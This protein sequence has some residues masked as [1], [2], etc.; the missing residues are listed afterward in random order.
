MTSP[1]IEDTRGADGALPPGRRRIATGDRMELGIRRKI[2]LV[3]VAALALTTA[4]H[5]LLA[6]YFTDRQNQ[7]AAFAL[8]D[9]DLLAWQNDLHDSTLQL[10]DRALITVSDAG[11]RNQLAEL[12]TLEIS[13]R[14]PV[15]AKEVTETS[16]TLGYVKSVSLSRLQVALRT[17]GFSSIAVRTGAT[18][19]HHVSTSDAG[20]MLPRNG[21]SV[22]ITTPMDAAGNLPLQSWPSWRESP[23]PPNLTR[24]LPPLTRPTTSF[25]VLEPD[26]TV[27]D[28]AVP[29]QGIID[30]VLVD[31]ENRPT[32]RF[33]SGVDIAGESRSAA[34]SEPGAHPSTFAVVV[35]RKVIDSAALQK[36]ARNTGKWPALFS[37]DGRHQHRLIDVGVSPRDLLKELK[38]TPDGSSPSYRGIV[39]TSQGSSYLA[40]R[41][42]DFEG[43]PRLVLALASSRQSTL[44]NIRETVTAILIASAG[45]LVVS[46][47]VGT[48]G[49]RRFL[50]PIVALTAAVK[51]RT[52]VT[53]AGDDAG[54][55]PLRAL[56]R[57]QPIEADAPDE[58]GDLARAFNTLLVKLHHSFETLEQRVQTR[59]EALRQ[60]TRYF[61]TLI[62]LLPMGVW[63]K[64]TESR[65][66]A[67][68]QSIAASSG[69]AVD[70]IVGKSDLEIWP[71]A[72]AEAQRSDDAAV[73][74]TRARRTVE[75]R[76]VRGTS[77]T[78]VE[79]Y[80][81][82][83]VDEDGT[84][85]GTVGIS[86]DISE[87][88]AAEA[89]REAA[90]DEARRLA[91]LR[92]DFL[93]QMSHELR[94]PLNG[95]LGYAQILLRDATL[96]ERQAG[97]LQV[98]QQ[99]GE[100]LL[101]LI[102]DLLDFAKIDSGKLELNPGT[103]PLDRFLRTIAG[104]I[105]VKAEQKGL[106]FVFEAA[107]DLPAAIRADEKRLREILFNLLANAI[108]F[109]DRG[110]ITFRVSTIAPAR[111]R[112]EVRDT[113]IGI[114]ADQIET[115]FQPFEQAGD[116]HR[117]AGG[118]GLGLAIGRQ[119]VRLMGG[120]IHVSSRSGEGSTFWFDLEL[121]VVDMEP[122][123]APAAAVVSG[124]VGP[125][126]K[127]LV[128][129]DVAESRSMLIDL[130]DQCGFDTSEAL[131][132]RE[133]IASIEAVRPDLVVMDVV[134]PDIDGLAATRHLRSLPQFA[135]LPIIAV[136]ASASRDQ[137][138][139][140]LAQGASA[141]VCK[142][143]HLDQFLAVVS[144][145]LN[146]EWTYDTAAQP[147]SPAH[148]ATGPL[149][150]PP[151]GELDELHRLARL[152]TMRDIV[153]WATRLAAS[154]ARYK[155]F[156]SHV[157]SLATT[158]QSRAILTF[159][160]QY[161]NAEGPP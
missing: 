36:V 28:I 155:L 104:I 78:W 87:R 44:Q 122:S 136:S 123:I 68:N 134:M 84:V 37:P 17:G 101:T 113:G 132:G 4:L 56:E 73:L 130:L 159:V 158:F 83:V 35:F 116:A 64:D 125:R 140:S 95:I 5:A 80:K 127:V 16:H 154:D 20:M 148:G 67:A 90:L 107:P 58:V 81:A 112:F 97:R 59:T 145:L 38:S 45:I 18:V 24:P 139:A 105:A 117:R 31:W 7:E 41:R 96:S 131:S 13:L 100:H 93:A 12:V 161:R 60:Q 43:E 85:L 9:R 137:E 47:A 32:S 46:L 11:V 138:Q 88:K 144:R 149:V 143:I 70:E 40:M 142:P 51:E 156:A 14:T 126:R 19:S 141:F 77:T 89:A 53:G 3:L 121:P 102:D 75:E 86:R 108:R 23:P 66:L 99:S 39:E 110:Q 133:T 76:R 92:S 79:T 30:D 55:L 33:L 98:I 157:R 120:D 63:L 103:V 153:E 54:G 21:T 146:L 62:D 111:L 27:I 25:E 6:W 1:G 8:L 29:L 119:L 150:P 50:N 147:T 42:W 109:T 52:L 71:R 15:R 34:S 152:G 74:A 114:P 160:E 82:A 69:H 124:Y 72:I 118:T 151:A 57:L 106:A 129:D 61:R 48:L 2:L 10:K 135:D 49:V 128:V 22:W 115:I 94:T 65:Y 91:R 26:T